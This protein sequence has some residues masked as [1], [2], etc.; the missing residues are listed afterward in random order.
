M[1]GLAL[2]FVSFLVIAPGCGASPPVRRAH[3]DAWTAHPPTQTAECGV[4][5]SACAHAASLRVRWPDGAHAPAAARITLDAREIAPEEVELGVCA[6]PGE[7]VLRIA[8]PLTE[9]DGT[10]TQRSLAATIE[11]LAGAETRLALSR[12]T[13]ATALAADATMVSIDAT[14]TV[15]ALG[16]AEL[17]SVAY[18]ATPE[19]RRVFAPVLS[20][21]FDAWRARLARV[22]TFAEQQDDVVLRTA[23]ADHVT[24]SDAIALTIAEDRPS[25]DRLAAIRRAMQT[26]IGAA[27]EMIAVEH[28]CPLYGDESPHPLL[29]PVSVDARPYASDHLFV[30]RLRVAIDDVEVLDAG[31]A[32]GGELI[33]RTIADGVV[34]PGEHDVVAEATFASR[35]IGATGRGERP[36]VLREERLAIGTEG[37]RIRVR[38]R[39]TGTRDTAI[40]VRLVV[41]ITAP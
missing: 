29:A 13:N 33:E 4:P 24:R 20:A 14:A 37:L 1:R 35:A 21:A 11:I 39:D 10:V 5:L 36:R 32:D 18:D 22:A 9:P 27:S 17:P 30:T 3:G 34:P 25:A 15:A 41:E 12:G 16:D 26:E 40:D 23:A 19:E 7:H 31:S 2:G 38:A 8:T 28:A 6:D